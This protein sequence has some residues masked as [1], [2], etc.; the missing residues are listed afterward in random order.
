MLNIDPNSSQDEI[1]KAYFNL[2]KKWHPDLNTSKEAKE[3]FSQ[4]SE[5]IKF[6]LEP[7]KL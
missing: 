5:Y 6:Y 3:K 1:K 7:T 4:I 2:A